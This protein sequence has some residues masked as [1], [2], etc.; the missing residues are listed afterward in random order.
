MCLGREWKGDDRYRSTDITKERGG[1]LGVVEATKVRAVERGNEKCRKD[2]L[3]LKTCANT[4]N[5]GRLKRK[6][7]C[8]NEDGVKK[9]ERRCS[10]G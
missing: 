8:R 5:N 10:I 3:G 1:L 7:T 4:E 9:Q 2:R 6:N